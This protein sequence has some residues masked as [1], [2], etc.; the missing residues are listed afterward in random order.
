MISLQHLM[1][2]IRR[3]AT[4]PLTANGASMPGSRHAPSILSRLGRQRRRLG[5]DD[6]GVA[7]IEFGFIAPIMLLMLIGIVDIS[8]AVSINWRMVNLNK[9]LADLSSQTA[10]LTTAQID[11]IFTA[12]AVVLSPYEG[13]LPRMTISSVIVGSDK[14][15]R[16][17]WSEAREDGRPGPL[18]KTISG[19]TKGTVVPLPNLQMAEPGISYIVTTT[20]LDFKGIISPEMEMNAK[21]LYFRP[22]AGNRDNGTEQVERAGQPLCK[23]V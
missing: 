12:S 3:P 21:T 19:L 15:A 14:I 18:L 11:N 16:V 13:K 17:C 2:R 20:V 6:S 9:S 1:R 4:P 7:A 22:R 5:N 8:N 23:P 10:T